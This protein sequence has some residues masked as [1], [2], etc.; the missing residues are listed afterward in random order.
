MY[1]FPPTGFQATTGAGWLL[2]QRK[3]QYT[4]VTVA[5]ALAIFWG[6]VMC[7]LSLYYIK[8]AL[9]SLYIVSLFI[10]SLMNKEKKLQLESELL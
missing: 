10:N 6:F 5:I 7:H 3:L 9:F 4:E 2:W 1:N 8:N